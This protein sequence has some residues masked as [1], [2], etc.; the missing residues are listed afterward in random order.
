M[1]VILLLDPLLQRWELSLDK[2]NV[3]KDDPMK[4]VSQSNDRQLS[5]SS[6]S[7]GFGGSSPKQI[8]ENCVKPTHIWAISG[9]DFTHFSS[10][11]IKSSVGNDHEHAGE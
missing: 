7:I 11:S 8:P 10:T 6:V 9:G 3:E 1:G 4:I 5:S 2:R